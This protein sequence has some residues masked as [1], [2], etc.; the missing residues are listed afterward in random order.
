[1]TS[2]NEPVVVARVVRAFGTGG[3]VILKPDPFCDLPLSD[4]QKFQA[5]IRSHPEI[6]LEVENIRGARREIFKF[7]GFETRAEAE[8]LRGA[9]LYVTMD[10]L[11]APESG[12]FYV[13]QLVG[14]RVLDERLGHVGTLKDVLKSPGSDLLEVVDKRGR[15]FLVPVHPELVRQID[16]DRM[17]ILVRLPDGLIEDP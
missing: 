1:V 8:K 2:G 14:A 17:E 9:D 13:F 16:A 5:H 7:K 15:D 12:E 6:D 11:P 3:E 10:Q 4:F